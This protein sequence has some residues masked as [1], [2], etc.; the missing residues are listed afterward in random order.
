MS[1]KKYLF[2]LFVLF[3]VFSDE[4]YACVMSL[5]GMGLGSGMKSR[6]MIAIAGITY[7]MLVIDLLNHRVTNRNWIQLGGLFLILVLY[8]FTGFFIYGNSLGNFNRYTAYLLLYGASCVPSAYV[9]MKLAHG[10]YGKELI[11]ILPFFVLFVSIIT[12]SLVRSSSMAGVM[13]GREEDDAFTYQSASYYLAFCFTY[14][15]FYVFYRKEKEEKRVVE[16][17]KTAI[18]II[19]FFVC[20]IGCLM[21][22]GRGA[23]VYIIAVTFYLIFRVVGRYGRTNMLTMLSL[24]IA[25][26]LMSYLAYRLQIFQSTGFSRVIEEL[27]TDE[28]RTTYWKQALGAFYDSPAFGNGIGSIW[29]TLGFYSHSIVTDLLSETGLIGTSVLFYVLAVILL[30]LIRRSHISDLDMFLLLFFLGHFIQSFFSGY[31]FANHAL[32]L[33]FGYVFSMPKQVRSFRE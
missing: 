14:C 1:L 28:Y 22:G 18:M 32:F 6:E 9:G 31:W 13:L 4:L 8:V 27:T 12:M 10:Q 29:W 16:S 20:A 30:T 24:A 21:G 5:T 19:L 23:F 7:F 3:V 15:F 11:R 26:F 17:I 25:A 2:P 33:S